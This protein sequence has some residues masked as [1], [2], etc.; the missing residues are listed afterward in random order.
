MKRIVIL[1][2]A[3]AAMSAAT[4]PTV[5]EAE[6]FIA[7]AEARLLVL[8]VDGS[9][10][11]WVKSTYITDDTE[12]L[13]AKTDER[14][15]NATVELAKQATRFDSLKLPPDVARKMK[16]LKL[17]LTLATPADAKESEELTRIAASMEGTYG[18]GKYC[19]PGKDACLDLEDLT[20]LMANSR[21]PAELL[22]GWRGWHAISRPMR[23]DFVRY[24]ALA[25][26]G[27][28]ELGFAD[29]GAMWRAKYDMPPDDFAKELDRL[30]DQ[31][32]PYIFRCTHTSGP[33]YANNTDPMWYP[34]MGPS[35]RTCWGICGPRP[36]I[37]SIRWQ[38]RRTPIRVSISPKS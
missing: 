3:A 31:V 9:R 6:K 22:D 32:R 14:L 30:W 33:N 2:A 25:N 29:T 20:R 23:P 18:K 19:P 13:A 28:R 5:R 38:R 17:S 15:I 10:A 24:V 35:R 36:G 7:D 11:D 12:A 8:S 4:P 21:N 26:K 1:M 16:L 37:T 34:P 27:A